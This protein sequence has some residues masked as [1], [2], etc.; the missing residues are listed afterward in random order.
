MRALTVLLAAAIFVP[1]ALAQNTL[2]VSGTGGS[3]G[4]EVYGRPKS[5][6]PGAACYAT[7]CSKYFKQGKACTDCCTTNCNT[8]A[9]AAL[10]CASK[11]NGEACGPSNGLESDA[12]TLPPLGSTPQTLA[13]VQEVGNAERPFTAG[14]GEVLAL[15]YVDG[16]LLTI[17]STVA[18]AADRLIT[19]NPDAQGRDLLNAILQL[20]MH[21]A[22]SKSIRYAGITAISVTQQTYTPRGLFGL[23]ASAITDPDAGVR[24]RALEAILGN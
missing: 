18:N 8:P 4:V 7:T 10:C 23:A 22:R 17:L 13:K 15:A 5:P 2:P 6:P 3:S 12:M 14:D 1:A 24:H 19:G 16:D 11:C 21:D 20:A 9:S